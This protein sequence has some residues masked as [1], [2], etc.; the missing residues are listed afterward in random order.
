MW[1]N[2]APHPRD[3]AAGL[4]DIDFAAIGPRVGEHFPDVALADQHGNQ[5]DLH[6]H[7]RGRRS[8]VVFHRS[9]DW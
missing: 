8:I 2:A 6:E 4:S 3:P 9:A 7:R 1:P 5:V